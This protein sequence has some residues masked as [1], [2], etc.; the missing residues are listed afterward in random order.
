MKAW[1]RLSLQSNKA[2]MDEDVAS[3][4]IYYVPFESNL[5]E[6]IS[7]SL[8]GIKAG[9]LYDIYIDMSMHLFISNPWLDNITPSVKKNLKG[10]FY[11]DEKNNLYLGT[12]YASLDDT[13]KWQV[14]PQ[15]QPNGC[16]NELGL[17]N[18]YNR[19][20]FVAINRNSNSI[21][22][23]D[24]PT[25]RYADNSNLFRIYWV[26]GIGDVFCEGTYSASVAGTNNSPA[27]ATIGVGL[28]Q[29]AYP[30]HW[31]GY[32]EQAAMNNNHIGIPLKGT[33]WINGIIGRHS[34]QAIEQGTPIPIQ[35]FGNNFACL[36]LRLSV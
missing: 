35:F 14:R 9:N 20:P 10:G 7:L 18:A 31:D 22:Q 6:E 24:S 3:N 23:Y 34:W 21:W 28:D 17:F 26:D 11:L 32:L 16:N 15:A 27:A 29:E 19:L 33:N 30:L 8:S 5:Y 25:L 36:T 4:N 12:I 13:V 1:G 2:R